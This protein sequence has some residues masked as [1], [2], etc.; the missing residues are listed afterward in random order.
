MSAIMDKITKAKIQLLLTQPFFSMLALSFK[1]EENSQINTADIDG[2][3]IRFNPDFVKDLSMEKLKGLIAHEVMHI[4]FMHHTRR[5]GR[6][7]SKWNKACDYAI[8]SILINSGFQLPDKGLIDKQFDGMSAEQIY[9]KIP[10][11]PDDQG[12]P[13]PGG[14][15][16]VKDAPG[17][18]ESEIR[19]K[20]SEAKQMIQKAAMIG[21]QQ[22]NLP[23]EFEHLIAKILEVK[24][25]WKVILNDF[26]TEKTR[27]DYTFSRPSN[28]YISQGLYLPSLQSVERGKFVLILDTS[29]SVDDQLLNEFGAEMQS[30]LSD[31]A[32]N[33]TVY[34]VDTKI[35]KIEEFAGDDEMIL[36]AKGRGGTDFKPAFDHMEK[37]GTDC[38]C[39]VYFTDGDCKSFPVDPGFPVLWAIYGND[40]F[41]PPFGDVVKVD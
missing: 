1:Y 25:N 9:A 21:K 13:D 18:T 20:E 8:N 39:A 19:Q 38:A 10:E 40:K 41:S 2:E 32:E 22:G 4:A 15:G 11:N 14:S 6:D 23:A 27:N 17:K 34:H 29:S 5:N 30:I 33:I 37:N 7:I 31:V 28:R 12:N 35:Q 26:L 36:K 24:V 3:R 16:G